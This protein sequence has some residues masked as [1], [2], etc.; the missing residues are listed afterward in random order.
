MTIQKH[1]P[2]LIAVI[3]S[4][5]LASKTYAGT[6]ISN[7]NAYLSAGTTQSYSIDVPSGAERVITSITWTSESSVAD[8]V[9]YLKQGSPANS[10]NYDCRVVVAY[11]GTCS[12]TNP[13]AG[14][15]YVG[16]QSILTHNYGIK[17]Y[18][19]IKRH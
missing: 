8:V 16:V 14:I 9:L 11:Q 6:S 7:N 2:I 13:Q 3:L 17:A 15:W 1:F 12:I 19:T 4:L 10:S 18:Y 5:V